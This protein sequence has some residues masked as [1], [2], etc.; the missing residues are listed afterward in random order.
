MVELPTIGSNIKNLKQF[1]YTSAKLYIWHIKNKIKDVTLSVIKLLDIAMT[2]NKIIAKLS[3][4][5]NRQWRDSTQKGISW[6]TINNIKLFELYYNLA[7][8]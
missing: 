3:L 5:K 4:D 1:E 7:I 8:I 6:K 2:K